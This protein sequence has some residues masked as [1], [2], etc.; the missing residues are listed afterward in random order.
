MRSINTDLKLK[1]NYLTFLA[2]L[3][4]KIQSAQVKAATTVNSQLIRLY[5][6]IGKSILQKQKEA[7][8][9]DKII[10]SL[11]KDLTI[12]FPEMKG[13]SS[14]NLKYMK[15]FAEENQD[16]SIGQQVVDQLPWGH[17]KGLNV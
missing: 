4:K 16:V 15:R 1:T 7:A 6:E 3:K 5:L 8:W 13:F 2:D 12:A 17:H 10:A 9:G 11:A 14:T